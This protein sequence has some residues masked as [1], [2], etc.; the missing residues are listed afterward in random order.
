MVTFYLTQFTAVLPTIFQS[1][2]LALILTYQRWY[3]D[4]GENA[5]DA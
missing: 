1:L 2:M 5:Q 4:D 3:L